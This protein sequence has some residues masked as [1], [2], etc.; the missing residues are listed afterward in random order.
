MKGCV[1]GLALGRLLDQFEGH[2]EVEVFTFFEAN[3]GFSTADFAETV[4]F[5]GECEK[6]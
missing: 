1:L 3:T 6:G 2:Y 4:G 5:H